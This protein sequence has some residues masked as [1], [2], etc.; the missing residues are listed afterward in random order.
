MDFNPLSEVVC[1]VGPRG[2]GKTSIAKR[3]LA[4]DIKYLGKSNNRKYLVIDSRG[5]DWRT[6]RY[7][8]S[9]T[10]NLIKGERSFKI[11]K[12]KC[13]TPYYDKDK[14]KAGDTLFGLYP[15]EMGLR[16]WLTFTNFTETGAWELKRKLQQV[17]E[18]FDS[19]DR[20]INFIDDLPESPKQAMMDNMDENMIINPATKR[21]LIRELS[22]AQESNALVDRYSP[23]RKNFTLTEDLIKEKIPILQFT[24]D[25][26]NPFAQFYIGKI[27]NDL[28]QAR[29]KDFSDKKN[30]IGNVTILIEEAPM[31]FGRGQDTKRVPSA[32]AISN[33]ILRGRTLGFSIYLI[34]QSLSALNPIALENFNHIILSANLGPSDKKTL[35]QILINKSLINNIYSLKYEPENNIREFMLIG[36]DRTRGMVFNAAL[37]P[38]GTTEELV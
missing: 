30:R 10:N 38:V 34:T 21:S 36:N 2:S 14:T 22:T 27:L 26:S 23:Y 8:Q 12:V 24:K 18:K 13:Y 17:P 15:G 4:Y 9:N 33:M 6:I 16:D 11:D 31:V 28:Y 5:I 37:A 7:K 29:N 19:P 3:I 1:I 20:L 25:D 32:E 35:N